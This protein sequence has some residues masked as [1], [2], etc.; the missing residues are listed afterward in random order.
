MFVS[1]KIRNDMKSEVEVNKELIKVSDV[2]YY[3]DAHNNE[4]HIVIDVDSNWFKTIDSDENIETFIF[5]ELQNGWHISDRTKILHQ[6]VDKF[7]YK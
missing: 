5:S 3:I 6:V 2:L 4:T 7:I 1:T